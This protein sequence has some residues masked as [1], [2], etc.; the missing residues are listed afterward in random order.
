MLGRTPIRRYF[1]S[2]TPVEAWQSET[3]P[4]GNLIPSTGGPFDDKSIQGWVPRILHRRLC[5]M[6]FSLP[7]YREADQ[8]PGPLPEQHELDEATTTLPTT[9]RNAAYGRRIVV[10]R[11]VFED[12]RSLPSP[13]FH[14][15]VA[16][17]PLLH[18]YFFSRGGSSAIT[19]L[20]EKEE[21]FIKA[22]ALRSSQDWIDRGMHGW[23][24]DLCTRH[25][26]SVLVVHRPS[27]THGDSHR[28]NILV[29]KVKGSSSEGL[30]LLRVLTGK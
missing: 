21:E 3:S 23:A 19:G 29:K 28:E 18:T 8:L 9:I 14:G 4:S 17:G 20:F 25:L 13:T 24:S 6:S 12:M 26:P 7:Y 11:S 15:S 10:L 5:E 16:H 1:L 2:T 27:F 22:I 30:R